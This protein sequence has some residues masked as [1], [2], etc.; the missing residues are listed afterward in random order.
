MIHSAGIYGA[1]EF[2]GE[3]FIEWWWWRGAG[4]TQG[5][6]ERTLTSRFSCEQVCLS[7]LELSLSFPNLL[8]RKIYCSKD[9]LLVW[10]TL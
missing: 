8:S 2:M 1:L 7:A 4:M 6:G 5:P 10:L 9:G 3:L